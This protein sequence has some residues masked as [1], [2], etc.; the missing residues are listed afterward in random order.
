MQV[1]TLDISISPTEMEHF[2]DERALTE[3]LSGSKWLNLGDGAD[4]AAAQQRHTAP[5]S[6]IENG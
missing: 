5:A 6:S 1:S 2:L 3:N 4:K